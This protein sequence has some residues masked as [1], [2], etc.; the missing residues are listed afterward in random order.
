MICRHEHASLKTNGLPSGLLGGD[1]DASCLAD[2]RASDL[3]SRFED[4]VADL[5]RE[6]ACHHCLVNERAPSDLVCQLRILIAEEAYLWEFPQQVTHYYGSESTVV[7]G[8]WQPADCRQI[9]TRW[10]DCGLID[11]IAT[12]W[13]TKV[14]SDEVVH[15]EYDAA[16]RKGTTEHGQY[17]IL[18]HDDAGA[19]LS[20]PS[21]WNADGDGGGVML[22]AS[23]E[24]DGLSFDAWFGKLA[25]LPDHLIYAQPGS[26]AAQR[27][28]SE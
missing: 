26:D 7:H 17:L 27:T 2:E 21:T 25:G 16:W 6:A 14:R 24:A 15:Y 23:D 19:L 20:D 18:A 12:S 10:F 13:A 1:A 11:C 3:A 9:L 8:P 22:C 28:A 5:R 4:I